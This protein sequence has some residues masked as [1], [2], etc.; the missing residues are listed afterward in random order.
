M[1]TDLPEPGPFDLVMYDCFGYI[2]LGCNKPVDCE[3]I[4][5]QQQDTR[6]DCPFQTDYAMNVEIGLQIR[7]NERKK[8]DQEERLAKM[9][10]PAVQ[11]A[12]A[13]FRVITP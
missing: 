9:G 1:A 3:Q 8:K 12:K 5:Y 11:K 2:S 7:W 10:N 13:V 6:D 4:E